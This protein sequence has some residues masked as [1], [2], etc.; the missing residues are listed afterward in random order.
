MMFGR[1]CIF[2]IVVAFIKR[3]L[4]INYIVVFRPAGLKFY[5]FINIFNRFYKKGDV[6]DVET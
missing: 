2:F 4:Y 3:E 1:S 5:V 6:R